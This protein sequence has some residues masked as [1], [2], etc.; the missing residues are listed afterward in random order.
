MQ[1]ALYA[2]LFIKAKK[3]LYEEGQYIVKVILG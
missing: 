3:Q 1:R 2:V